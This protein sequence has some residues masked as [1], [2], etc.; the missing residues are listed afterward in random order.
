MAS[1]HGASLCLSGGSSAKARRRLRTRLANGAPL[2]LRRLAT[3]ILR[4]KE[5]QPG[6]MCAALSGA[7]GG[8]C[9]ETT[10]PRGVPSGRGGGSSTKSSGSAEEDGKGVALAAAALGLNTFLQTTALIMTDPLDLVQRGC[11]RN[12]RKG[13]EKTGEQQPS[14]GMTDI[15]PSST[16]IGIVRKSHDCN[17]FL[18]KHTEYNSAVMKMLLLFFPLF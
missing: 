10:L 6:G 12:H 2:G 5:K 16:L 7:P 1:I 17:D 15:F 13:V 9:A 8:A 4:W 3:A 14:G 11:D 18:Y